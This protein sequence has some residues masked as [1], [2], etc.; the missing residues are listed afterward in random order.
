LELLLVLVICGAA[1]SAL[2]VL[3]AESEGDK[4]M[5]D[6]VADLSS[7]LQGLASALGLADSEAAEDATT[8]QQE[9]AMQKAVEEAQAAYEKEQKELQ[10]Q[11]RS[12][13]QWK[14]SHEQVRVIK[15]GEQA[16][17]RTVNNFCL[18]KDGNLL[19][20][21]GRRAEAELLNLVRPAGAQTAAADSAD[22]GEILVFSPDGKQLGAWKLP[23][24]PQAICL[25]NDATVF[26]GGAGRLCKLSAEGQV[27]LS[28]DAPS[29]AELP[30]L[31]E[32]PEKK[33]E[34]QGVDVEAARKA[35]QE[36]IAAL[37]KKVEEALNEYQKIVEGAAQDLKP[38]DDAAMEAYQA[39]MREPL[40]KYLALQ[41]KLEQ[42]QMTPEVRAAQLRM[43]REQHLTIT[44]LAVT[45]RDVF[46]ACR[47]AKGYGYAVWRTDREFQNPKKVVENLAGC[48]GQMDIQANEGELW[49]AHNARHKAEHY[50]RDGQKLTSF[51]KRDRASA[52]GFG[53]CC[54]PKNLRFAV[55]GEVFASESGPPTCVKRFTTTGEFRGV[56]VVAPWTS[57]CVRVTTEFHRDWDQFFV[58]NSGEDSIHVFARTPAG[59]AAAGP[60]PGADA[61]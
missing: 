17:N 58:L 1:T 25:A 26:V 31:P 22:R 28:A 34:P 39:K 8:E 30:P 40:G 46:L 43:Q 4:P 47:S 52:D 13:P 18:N 12:D 11:L 54:E 38:D 36:E 41:E 29:V 5:A 45:D 24:E 48:C 7:L 19:V 14:P 49:V 57:G 15:V 6:P 51:G 3:A 55:A 44:G 10:E 2:P 53:G 37:Q 59:A 27:L 56:A 50:D 60:A 32:E 21:C 61:K 20:C 35:K 42:L 16:Q 33:A 9:K 23:F